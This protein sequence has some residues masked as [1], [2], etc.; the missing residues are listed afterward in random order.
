MQQSNSEQSG[1]LISRHHNPVVRLTNS[2]PLKP[3]VMRGD[4]TRKLGW[5]SPS[6]GVRYPSDQI[7]FE[8]ELNHP[9]KLTFELF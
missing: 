5:V 8:G 3:K 6:F 1:V 4:E 2:G 9:S 7:I